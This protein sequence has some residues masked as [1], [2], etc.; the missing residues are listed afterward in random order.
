MHGR[1]VAGYQRS[2]L[3][4]M[5][6]EPSYS[7][8]Q[9][10]FGTKS[11]NWLS[12]LDS[13]REIGLIL[14]L[15]AGDG[16]NSRFLRD[17]YPHAQLVALD[18]SPIRCARCRQFV[19]H[20]PVCGNGMALPFSSQSFDMIVSTQVIEHVPDDQAFVG[21]VKRVLTPGG[22]CVVSS[23]IKMRF[24]WY[25]YRN[26]RGEWA[27]DPTHVK[28]YSSAQE[29][30]NMFQGWF[31]ILWSTTERFRFSPARFVY[32]LL[33]KLGMIGNP[34]PQVFS[35]SRWAALLERWAVAVPRYRQITIAAESDLAGASANR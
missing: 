3:D 16:R 18:V 23:V 28:E 31:R 1:A 21:E 26:K 10:H 2:F 30:V 6:Y 24:G 9:V 27:L 17:V 22:L 32:R 29:F 35:K 34:D 13:S 20:A 15:G 19:D 12:L 7:H 14:D 25:F 8:T 5:E 4:S 33:V 11:P